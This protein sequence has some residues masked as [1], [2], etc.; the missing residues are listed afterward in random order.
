MTTNRAGIAYATSKG[1]TNARMPIQAV[2][3]QHTPLYTTLT[4]LSTNYLVM[5]DVYTNEGGM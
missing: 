5:C 1:S 3:S 2:G 4:N